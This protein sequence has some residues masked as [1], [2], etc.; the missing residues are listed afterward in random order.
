MC[1]AGRATLG[2]LP[3]TAAGSPG[4]AAAGW[5]RTCELAEHHGL[6]ALLPGCGQAAHEGL[7]LG[8]LAALAARLAAARLLP[9]ALALALARL[10]RVHQLR[11]AERAAAERALRLLRDHRLDAPAFEGRRAGRRR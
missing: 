7:D 9:L 5:Q 2:L 6:D 4:P 1:A 11:R 8:A 3:A 10:W